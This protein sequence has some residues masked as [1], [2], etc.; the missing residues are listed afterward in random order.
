MVEKNFWGDG[1]IVKTV[2]ERVVRFLGG[3]DLILEALI[4]SRI[5]EVALHVVRYDRRATARARCPRG[6]AR[7][8]ELP[9]R[10]FREALRWSC[11]SKEKPTMA[12]SFGRR[13]S[14]RIEQ[15]GEKFAFGEV[16]ACTE[17]HHDAGSR[18]MRRLPL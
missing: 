2:A 11:W 7:I 16:A 6:E 15:R 3:E 13:P 1:E 18:G 17:N 5:A 4:G 9:C 8:R 14:S 10:A 12:K